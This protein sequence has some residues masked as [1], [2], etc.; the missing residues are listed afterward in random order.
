[1]RK[2][3]YLIAILFIFSSCGYKSLSNNQIS[4][5]NVPYIQGDSDGMLTSSIIKELEDSGKFNFK[6]KK[7]KLQLIASVIS[8]G[9][10]Q[11]GYKH[12]RHKD[13]TV[14]KNVIP[15][16]GRNTTKVKVSLI[17][18]DTNNEVFG[19]FIFTSFAD[20]DY[21]DEDSLND[22][23][24]INPQNQRQTVLSFSLGQLES[25][26][27]AQT[28]AKQNVYKKL[29]KQIVDAICAVY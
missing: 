11:I 6:K 2:Y 13:G 23:S 28:A 18:K 24:F 15:I 5:I 14:K 4:T 1:M 12:D 7:S 21:V 20:Y 17:Q 8:D 27:S 16:E 22:L 10:E 19:P 9:Q 25:I 29:A 26:A 3:F